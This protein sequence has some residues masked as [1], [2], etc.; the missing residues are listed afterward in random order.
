MQEVKCRRCFK[1]LARCQ[2]FIALEIKCHRC[3]AV[4]I[5]SL[6]TTSTLPE[7]L[8]CQNIGKNNV[9]SFLSTIHH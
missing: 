1:L 6:S 9:S 4:N 7:H 2:Q 3:K 8:E 5:F